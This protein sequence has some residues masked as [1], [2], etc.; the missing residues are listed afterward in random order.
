[1]K[2]LE[3]LLQPGTRNNEETQIK[4]RAVKL[5]KSLLVICMLFSMTLLS[6]CIVSGPR[7]G[8]PPGNPE[9]H[10]HNEHHDNGEHRGNDEHHD[11]K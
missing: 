7:H 8:G 4:G 3:I 5:L 11:R 10:G 9:R 1:M 2:A 6:S